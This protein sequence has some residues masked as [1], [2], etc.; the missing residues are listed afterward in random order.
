MSSRHPSSAPNLAWILISRWV[1]LVSLHLLP[2]LLLFSPLFTLLQPHLLAFLWTHLPDPTT[3][4]PPP[5]SVLHPDCSMIYSLFFSGFGRKATFVSASTPELLISHL[6]LTP[7]PH[8]TSLSLLHCPTFFCKITFYLLLPQIIYWVLLL[9]SVSKADTQIE[10]CIH[11]PSVNPWSLKGFLAPREHLGR[12]NEGTDFS[13]KQ[14]LDSCCHSLMA[15][16]FS[17]RC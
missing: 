1:T 12:V 7:W 16:G 8:P 11:F 17:S 14:R 3:G 15:T 13:Q 6:P 2:C 4:V 9:T 5:W 10:N